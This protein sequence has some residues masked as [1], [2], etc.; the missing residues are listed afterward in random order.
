MPAAQPALT[1][2]VGP[3][4]MLIIDAPGA[5][6]FTN[7]QLCELF[8]YSHDQLIGRDVEMLLPQRFR[9]QHRVHRGKYVKYMRVRPMGQGLELYGLR[10]DGTEFPLEISLSPIEHDGRLLIVA[11]IR[12]MTDRQ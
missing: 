1:L 3:D 5:I 12:D 8:G 6:R 11:A 7:R 4:A 9:Q 10:H 2:D